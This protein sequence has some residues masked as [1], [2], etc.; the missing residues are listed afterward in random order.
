MANYS[1]C[2][3]NVLLA[4][5]SARWSFLFSLYGVIPAISLTMSLRLSTEDYTVAWFAPLHFEAS[6]A[7]LMLDEHHQTGEI[8]IGVAS[9]MAS[10]VQR[11]LRNIKT[12]LLVGIGAGIP[13]YGCD[14]RLGDVVVATPTK[15]NS[16]V[17]GYDMIK[18]EP[19]QTILK[20]WQNA[21]DRH[22]R[23]AITAL[24]ATRETTARF[25]SN[26]DRFRSTSFSQRPVPPSNALC[27]SFTQPREPI[28]H[29]GCILSGNSV[30]KSAKR[31][32][33]LARECNAFAIEME[34]AGM[35]NTLPVAVIRGISDWADA[36]KN[37]VWQEYAAATAAA[38][39]KELLACLDGSH[40]I[41]H[42]SQIWDHPR[43]NRAQLN[44]LLA[45]KAAQYAQPNMDWQNS[46]VD[47]LKILN[48]DS[49]RE[50]RMRLAQ[51]WNILIGEDG[52]ASRNVSLH[53]T[54]TER[55]AANNGVIPDSL[56]RGLSVAGYAS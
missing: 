41:S 48:L 34:A 20:Q 42:Q 4:S 31:R 54:I 53:R 43:M 28:I 5:K 55:L 37:D 38:V 47:L 45:K 9:Y 40:S 23:S 13:R 24:R 46:V 16:G 36:E 11:D 32:D 12:G 30:I 17:Y 7:I 56:I 1:E 26:L 50:A 52:S 19:E 15:N 51:R 10:E 33:E 2:Y 22:I 44:V 21:P 27:G 49:S 8:G 25:M 39:A 18:V 29:Y 6:A 14:M 35:M 3:K